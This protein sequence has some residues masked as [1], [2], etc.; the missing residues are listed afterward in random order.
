M[1]VEVLTVSTKGQVVLP[2]AMRRA[3]GIENGTRLAAY[4]TDDVIVLKPLDLPVDV[5][6]EQWLDVARKSL[7]GED[8]S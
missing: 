5:E 8:A 1:D 3:L 6:F 4:A 2:I 7:S